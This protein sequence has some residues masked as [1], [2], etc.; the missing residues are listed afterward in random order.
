MLQEGQAVLATAKDHEAKGDHKDEQGPHSTIEAQSKISGD[1]DGKGEEAIE[2]FTSINTCCR[3]GWERWGGDMKTY[4]VYK[5][6]ADEM[7]LGE[8]RRR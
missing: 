4:T 5:A 8:V 1:G 6:T 3:W 2:I 7:G